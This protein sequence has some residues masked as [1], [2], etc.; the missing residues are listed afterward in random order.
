MVNA[1]SPIQSTRNHLACSSTKTHG[2][3]QNTG[4]RWRNRCSQLTKQAMTKAVYSGLCSYCI[5]R[6]SRIQAGGSDDIMLHLKLAG[7]GVD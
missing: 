1:I 7:I 6:S 5:P 4:N 3:W 2:R